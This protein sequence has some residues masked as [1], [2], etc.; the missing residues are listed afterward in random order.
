MKKVAIIGTQGVPACYGGFESLVENIIGENCS[1]DIE[2]TVYCSGKDMTK[3]KH[4]TTYKGAKLKYVNIHANGAVSKLA[5]PLFHN[6]LKNIKQSPYFHKR[7]LCR[8]SK[9]L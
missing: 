5:Q 1:P 9:F 8:V 3:T 4:L 6:M 7:G 2:Y